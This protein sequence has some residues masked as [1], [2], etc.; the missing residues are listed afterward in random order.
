MCKI[1]NW[2]DIINKEELKEVV[3][4]LNNDG[5]VVFPTETV[6]GIGGKATSKMVIDRVY[7]A[8][9][10]ARDKAVNILVSNINEIEKYA[11]ISSELERKIIK[12]F[13]PGP[14]TIILKKKFDFGDYFTSDNDT[15]G[16]RVPD[17]KIINTILENVE[18]PLIAPSANISGM[19]SGVNIKSIIDDFKNSVDAFIDGG[20]AKFGL[21]STIVKVENN[22]I[23][24]LRQGEIT[25]DDIVSKITEL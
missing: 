4:I 5:V 17:N 9:K 23:K 22:N 16:V 15:I 3:Q 6:Y 20:D 1:F 14:I 19:P 10:R 12:N 8:K 2:K 25:M 21:S 24:I 18:F 13:M 11:I 7:Q